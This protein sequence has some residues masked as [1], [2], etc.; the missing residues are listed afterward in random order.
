MWL[1]RR[2]GVAGRWVELVGSFVKII[3]LIRSLAPK[4]VR[5]NNATKDAKV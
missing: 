2:F 5:H 3:E 4:S 1:G